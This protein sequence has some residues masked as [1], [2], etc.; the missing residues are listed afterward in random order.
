[1][2]EHLFAERGFRATSVR[3]IT[4]AAECNVAAVNYHFGGKEQLYREVIRRRLTALRERRIGAIRQAMDRAGEGANLELLLRVFTSSFVEPLLHESTGRI[5]VRLMAWEMVDRQ[6][7][8]EVF[9]AEIMA[10]VQAAL[11]AALGRACPGLDARVAALCA[12]SLVAQLVHIVHRSRLL[13]GEDGKTAT[14]G[15]R[16]RLEEL[17]RHTVRFS[18]AGILGLAETAA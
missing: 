7:P 6:L 2:A 18:A 4:Q 16:R 3:R 9:E 14:P 8:R 11:V 15:D 13:E 5:W 12:Q 1:M 17:V 10:P